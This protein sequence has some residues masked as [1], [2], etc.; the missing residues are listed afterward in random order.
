M[1]IFLYYRKFSRDSRPRWDWRK[2][3]AG[4]KARM[5]SRFRNVYS[6]HTMRLKSFIILVTETIQPFVKVNI[7]QHVAC[8]TILQKGKKSR[9]SN[10]CT[11]HDLLCKSSFEVPLLVKNL[12]WRQENTN[13]LSSFHLRISR[14]Q[15]KAGKTRWSRRPCWVQPSLL[16]LILPTLWFSVIP[17]VSTHSKENSLLRRY[18]T[19][20]LP[21][22]AIFS[23]C[24]A[25]AAQCSAQ[26]TF[27]VLFCD[28]WVG[29]LEFATWGI[30]HFTS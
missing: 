26:L 19:M 18:R 8:G 20:I 22:L 3:G 14:T 23:P 27:F 28:C 2:V 15:G 11:V 30:F 9:S 29:Q 4:W 12:L 24:F 5:G 16:H 6:L 25:A 1:C 21:D 13:Y 10:K 17:Y 7:F